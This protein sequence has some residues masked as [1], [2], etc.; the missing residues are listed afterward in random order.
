MTLP[1][2]SLSH[3]GFW[4][5]T[6]GV[7]LVVALC[8]L[9]AGGTVALMLMRRFKHASVRDRVGQFVSSELATPTEVV[10]ED[11]ETV[12]MFARTERERWLD[13]FRQKLEIARIER[14]PIDI[15]FLT[16]AASVGGAVFVVVLFKSVVAGLLPLIV[17]PLIA[18]ALINRKLQHERDEFGEQLPGHLQELAAAL[19]AGH[20]MVSGIAVMAEGASEPSRSEFQRVIADEQLGLPLESALR[21]VAVRMDANDIEQVS[22]VA[23][24]HRQTGG[25]M[26][27]VLD[28]VAEAIRARAELRREL[29]TLTAQARGSRWIVTLIPPALLLVIDLL[30]P[31]YL[32]PLFNTSTGE[33][34]LIAAAALIICGSIVMAKIVRI[35]A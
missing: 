27:E 25:N 30:N 33:A 12:G 11:P 22:L 13:D 2:A 7:A 23:E 6:A 28:R 1:I 9:V 8:A 19:R 16:L 20:S 32:R 26:A 14:S 17:V 3:H 21:S 35:E 18:K 34:L 24:L 29:Q 10:E 31:A 15:L 5:S 4:S